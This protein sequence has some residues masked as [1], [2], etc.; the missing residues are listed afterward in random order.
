MILL[1]LACVE[2]ASV[3]DARL[4]AYLYPDDDA[5]DGVLSATVRALGADGSTPV[6]ARVAWYSNVDGLLGAKDLD[7]DGT[8]RIESPLSGVGQRVVTAIVTDTQGNSGR[9]VAAVDVEGGEVPA[10]QV[11]SPPDGSTW[12]V[13]EDIRFEAEILTEGDVRAV[14]SDATG[15][16]LGETASGGELSFEAPL[17]AGRHLLVLRAWI[18]G[19][20]SASW[21]QEVT[22][23]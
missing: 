18:E 6:G 4:F 23:E 13:G 11:V 17:A 1:A 7:P 14:W 19:G 9:A 8:T 21:F 5:R 16:P 22:V 20:R 15:G 10:A 2:D 12:A 3:A